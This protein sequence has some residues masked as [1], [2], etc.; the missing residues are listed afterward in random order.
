MS[1]DLIPFGA[2]NIDADLIRTSGGMELYR[3]KSQP[4]PN[5]RQ[6][7]YTPELASRILHRLA[8]GDSLI[9]VCRNEDIDYSVVID[10]TIDNPDGFGQKYARARLSGCYYINELCLEIADDS[11]NDWMRKYAPDNAG[12]V[13]NLDHL[14]RTK[15]RLDQRK[16]FLSKIC[17]KIFGDKLDLTVKPD[18]SPLASET[19]VS[20]TPEQLS[21]LDQI[22]ELAKANGI[23][24]KLEGFVEIGA[25]TAAQP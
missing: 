3:H 18:V 9:E 7:K 25:A 20:G 15:M 13:A 24:I 2:D 23:R 16:F 22:A 14:A 4:K 10:W 12:W 11:R 5:V 19:L 1:T 6:R 21:A 8:N 17:P